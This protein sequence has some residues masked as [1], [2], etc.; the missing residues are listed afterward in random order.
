MKYREPMPEGCPPDVAEEIV[1]VQHVFRLV[2]SSPPTEADFQSQ[3]A[4]KPDRNFVDVNECQAS[5]LSVFVRRYDAERLLKM[6]KMRGR[7]VC[8]VLLNTGAGYIQKTGKSSH[9]TWWPFADYNILA[10]CDVE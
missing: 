3:R 8:R 4:E 9:H 6:P 2:L 10:Q 5:G 1:E 7:K